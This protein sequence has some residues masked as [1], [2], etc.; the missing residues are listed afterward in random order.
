MQ[1]SSKV[2]VA[3]P[4]VV[5]P[6]GSALGLNLRISY[7]AAAGVFLSLCF[8]GVRIPLF[9]FFSSS[10]FIFRRADM[11]VFIYVALVCFMCA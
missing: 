11:L 3:F 1:Y 10:S 4:G 6:L 9:K 2:F 7:V 5:V 8:L